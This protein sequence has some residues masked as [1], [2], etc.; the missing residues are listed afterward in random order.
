MVTVVI[1]D[2]ARALPAAL[3]A[4]VLPGWFWAAFLRRTDG[5]AERLAYSSALSLATVPAI[6]IA[7]ARILG[8]GITLGVAI[9]SVLIVAGSGALA[10]RMRGAAADSADSPALPSPPAITDGLSL[11]LVAAAIALALA[12]ALGLRTPGWPLVASL[13]ALLAAGLLGRIR[14]GRADPEA[15]AASPAAAPAGPA[16]PA[17]P[18]GPGADDTDGAAPRPLLSKRLRAP[19]LLIV[20]ALTAVRIYIGVVWHD[21]PYLRGEDQF[22]HAVMTEQMMAHGSYGSYLIYPPGFSALGAVAC[23]FSGLPPLALYPVITPALVLLTTIAAYALAK[24]LWGWE[25]GLAAATLSGLVLI[26]PD[27]SFGGGLYPDL[28]AAFLLMVMVVTALISLYTDRSVRSGVLLAVLGAAVVLFHTVGTIYLVVTLGSVVVVCLPYLVLRGGPEGRAI[29]RAMIASLAGLGVLALAYAWHIYRLGDIL[30]GHHASARD[31]VR[32]DVGSQSVLPARD[33]LSWVGSPVIWLGV[34]GFGVLAASVRFLR[35]PGQVACAL[36]LLTWGAVMYL[37][38]RTTVDGFPQRFERDVGAPLAILA[39]MALVVV[40]RSVVQLRPSRRAVQLLAAAA[41]AVVV[42]IAVVQ[43][44]SNVVTDSEKSRQ[45]L[46]EPVAAAGAWLK[47]HNTGGTI[48]STPDMNRGITNRAVLAMG[49]YTGLQSYPWARLLHPRSLPTAGPR[50]LWD[51]HEVLSHPASCRSGNILARQ[52]VRYVFLYRLGDEA[53]FAG[54]R[55]DRDRY[56]VAYQNR[57][58]V[59]Y[60]P[61]S[62]TACPPAE[63]TANSGG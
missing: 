19:A 59:I 43:T 46:P 25:F 30:V 54:F 55:A 63:V 1:A 50:P 57:A 32:L 22:S 60:E 10:C 42:M 3:A 20:L 52:D 39:A 35:R 41:T 17:R 12:T 2:L 18:A 31:T 40:A 26:G 16:K 21:W 33:L 58:V 27:V 15:A 28:L 62:P 49:Y 6:A 9:A 13:L 61:R 37:G 53:N 23:R 24:R 14:A 48:I 38:S 7:L 5:L 56:R 36:T 45:V 8:S 11:V 47:L 34:L 29:A 4:G 44:V 51:S